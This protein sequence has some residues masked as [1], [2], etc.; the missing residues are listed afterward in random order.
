MHADPNKTS[1][2]KERKLI[3]W[4]QGKELNSDYGSEMN[5]GL[6]KD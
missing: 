2:V 3:F 6:F 1:S 5:S 4:S